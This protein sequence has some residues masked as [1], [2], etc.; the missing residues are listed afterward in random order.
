MSQTR[1][2][3][4]VLPEWRALSRE[5]SLVSQLI[6]SGATALG[7]ASY[8]DGFGEYYTAFFGLSIGIERLAKLILT[9]DHAIENDG[10]L[11]E[12]ASVRRFGHKLIDL[13]AKVDQITSKHGF[14]LEYLK[15]TDPICWA[16]VDCLDAFADASRGRYANFEAI[17]N[18]N[19]DPNN[20]PVNRWWTKVVEPILDKHY[21]GKSAEAGVRQRAA[22][23]G[24]MMGPVS[25]V[26]HIDENGMMMTDVA[27][28]SERTG[29]T[30]WARKY[31]RFYTLAVVRWLS[32]IF[33]KLVNEAAY[34]KKIDALFGHNESFTTYLVPDSFLLTRKQWPLK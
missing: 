2:D 4:F 29:Q 7:R 31:G 19:F 25:F 14:T 10:A 15:P 8:A 5:A 6:G 33:D 30:E 17:G 34:G 1:P 26:R 24:A 13:A 23:I 32:D 18:P 27:V 9:A 11:P 20:E 16:A 12:Q 22:V 3:P 21:R 28:A